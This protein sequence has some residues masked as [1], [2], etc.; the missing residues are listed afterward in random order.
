MFLLL[1][2]HKED[3]EGIPIFTITVT[4]LCIVVHLFASEQMQDSLA[5]DP[6]SWNVLTMF[7]SAFVH[8]DLMHILGNLF[9]FVCFAGPIETEMKPLGYLLAFAVF[10]VITSVFYSLTASE[11]IPTIGLSGVV[12]GYMGMFLMRFPRENIRSF[13]WFLVIIRTVNI[14]AFLF[15][16]AFLGFEVAAY[17][18]GEEDGVNHIAHLSGFGAGVFIKFAFWSVLANFPSRA[19]KSKPSPRIVETTRARDARRK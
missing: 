6:A 7:T 12:W 16:L 9:F 10:C 1:P 8:G 11:P 14:P 4:A 5:Y 18:Q 13:L 17:N 15:V 2:L 19:T 3:H